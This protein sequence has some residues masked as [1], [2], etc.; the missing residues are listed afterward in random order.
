M[1]SWNDIGWCRQ[2]EMDQGDLQIAVSG[3]LG[4]LA[5]Y[6]PYFGRDS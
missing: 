6:L 2:R 4:V 3:G 5:V 1:T